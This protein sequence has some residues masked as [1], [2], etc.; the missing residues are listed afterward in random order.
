LNVLH[1]H[2]AGIGLI[3]LD[4]TMPGMSIDEIVP[5]IRV[6][7]NGVP[8]LLNSGYTSNATVNQMLD[9]GSVQGF[10][11]KPYTPGQ[12]LEAVRGLLRVDRRGAVTGT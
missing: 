1:E 9:D 6:L 7:D 4:M 11:E 2:L 3:L 10:L 8:I 5:A 12:L